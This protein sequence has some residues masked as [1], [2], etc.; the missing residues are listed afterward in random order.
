MLL[1]DVEKL[2]FLISMVLLKFYF[3]SFEIIVYFFNE[4]KKVLDITKI[5]NKYKLYTK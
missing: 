5:Y 2:Q 1:R 3:N 4:K